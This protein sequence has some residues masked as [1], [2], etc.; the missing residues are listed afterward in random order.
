MRL[1]LLVLLC[2]AI[3]AL[4]KEARE[5]KPGSPERKEIMDAMRKPT[6]REVG[7]DVQFTGEVTVLG[8]WAYFG[9]NVGPK[10]GQTPTEPDLLTLDFFALLRNQGGKWVVLDSGFAGDIGFFLKWREEYPDSPRGLYD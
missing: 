4:A 6:S 10:P 1:I 5:P 7:C 3:A 9:G 8:T 2:T